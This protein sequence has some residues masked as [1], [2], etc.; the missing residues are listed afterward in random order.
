MNNEYLTQEQKRNK[1]TKTIGLWA[2]A[3]VVIVGGVWG[4]VK[5]AQMS[6]QPTTSNTGGIPGISD[7]DKSLGN[8]DA[9]VQLIEYADFQ[10]PACKAADPLIKQLL[11]EYPTQVRFAYR[12]FPLKTI[13]TTAMISAAA[14]EAASM[15]GKFW[16]MK[17]LLYTNQEAWAGQQNADQIFVGYAQQL[18]LDTAKF[19]QDMYSDAVQK[20]VQADYD[21][22]GRLKL[23]H[24]PTFVVDGQV[25][26][27]PSSYEGYKQLIENKL[28]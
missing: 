19:R 24:T 17:T 6:P 11:A 4:V 16:E 9:K 13:H 21:E 12:Y 5:L 3:A 27:N 23:D 7:K 22:A 1:L 28:K 14:A 26:A 10:C 18:N 20:K 2:V 8:A 25:V 15:Q